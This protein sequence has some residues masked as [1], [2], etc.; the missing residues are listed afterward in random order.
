[1]SAPTS[2]P[3]AVVVPNLNGAGLVGRCVRAALAAGAAEVVVVDDGSDDD[4]PDEARAAGARVFSSRGKGFAA[5][6]NDGVAG[7]Q[8][9][10]VLVL[11]SDCFVDPGAVEALAE[12]I[13]ANERIAICGANLREADGSP[14]RSYGRNVTLETAIRSS[15][16]LRTPPPPELPRTGTHAVP[17]VPLA[18]AIVRREA[19]EELGGLD[20]RYAFYFEDYDFCWRVSRAGWI[21]AVSLE[22]TALHFGGG[23]SSRRDPQRWFRQ[24]NESRARYLR[25]RYPRGWLAFVAAWVPVAA[26]RAVAWRIRGGETGRAWAASYVQSIVGMKRT[27][28]NRRLQPRRRGG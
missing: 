25:K 24:Y 21:V 20:E 18:C 9:T 10:C 28:V 17:F 1:V 13:D 12:A 5:A 27:R 4:S 23:S 6:V 19:W 15:F 11:N 16:G 7:V 8:T 2:T 26:A 22:A 3:V 14:S